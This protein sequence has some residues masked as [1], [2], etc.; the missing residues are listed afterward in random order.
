MKFLFASFFNLNNRIID[1]SYRSRGNISNKIGLSG[2]KMGH[3]FCSMIFPKMIAVSTNYCR[4]IKNNINEMHEFFS[5][6]F[7][8]TIV[9]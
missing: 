6:L 5:N 9:Q 8:L 2:G 4:K 7:C 1:D 3:L